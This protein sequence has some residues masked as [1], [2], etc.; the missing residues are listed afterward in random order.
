MRAVI[1]LLLLSVASSVGAQDATQDVRLRVVQN[2]AT[3][4]GSLVVSVEVRTVGRAPNHTLGS[5]TFDIDYEESELSEP[6][7]E[8]GEELVYPAFPIPEYT[9]TFSPTLASP[10]NPSQARISIN[11]INSGLPDNEGA[12]IGETF[13]SIGTLTFQKTAA[14]VESVTLEV[15]RGS[16]SVGYYDTGTSNPIEDNT[17][18]VGDDVVAVATVQDLSMRTVSYGSEDWHLVGAPG[19]GATVDGLIGPIFT[20]GFPGSDAGERGTL[21]VAFWN[22]TTGSYDAPTGPS[23]A[24]PAGVGLAVYAFPDEDSDGNDDPYP[25]T[26]RMTFVSVWSLVWVAVPWALM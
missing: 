19:V 21:N 17:G 24:V 20:Q 1:A 10:S 16:L 15:V 5:A 18:T 22:E 26:S 25:K 2:E 8:I 23:A 14:G 7:F 4:G 6:T 9:F 13:V 3:V 12:Q 11:G